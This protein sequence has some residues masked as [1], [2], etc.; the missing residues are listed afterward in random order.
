MMI[1]DPSILLLYFAGDKR[2]ARIIDLIN[3][4]KEDGCMLEFSMLQ[5]ADKLAKVFDY[6]EAARRLDA[7]K[8]SRIKL[9]GF[10]Y[11]IAKKAIKIRKEY[12]IS[13]AGAYMIALAINLNATLVTT[14][15]RLMFEGLKVE[16]IEP[17]F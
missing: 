7:I 14:N 4:S 5:L 1:I 11:E 6:N 13:F 10:D 2:V 3:D 17:T 8:N 15:K 16:Y 12:D 9:I